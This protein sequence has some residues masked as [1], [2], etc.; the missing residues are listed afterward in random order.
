MLTRDE[1]KNYALQ[2]CV[3]LMERT[4]R[5]DERGDWC[6]KAD[7]VGFIPSVLENFCRPFWG[8]APILAVGENVELQIGDRTISVAEYV[9][10]MLKKGLFGGER[11]SWDKYRKYFEQYA[12]ENQ[13]ITELAG[14]AISLFFAREAL[15]D[16]MDKADKERIAKAIYEMAEVAYEHSWPNN[17]YWFPLFAIT[18]LK[19]LGYHYDRTDEMLR[20]GLA[21][22]DT[23]YLGDGWYKD[24]EFGRFDYYEAWS[25]H[26]YPL[27]WTLIADDTFEGYKEYRQSF[28]RRTNLFLP[29]FTHWFGEDGA[30]VPFGRS[31]SYRFAAC[32]L[33]PVAV[34]A[35][36]DIKPAMAGRITA[37]NIGFFKEQCRFEETDIIPEG[38]LYHTSNV[39]ES[40]TSDGGAYWCCKAFLALLM[41]ENHPFWHYEDAELPAEKGNY[42]VVPTYKDIHILFEGHRGMVT[43]YNNT[44]QYYQ[45]GQHTHKFGDMR[46][47]YG[48]FVYS[49]AVGFGCSSCDKVSIDN[50]VSLMTTDKSMVSHRLG[51]RDL[52]YENGALHSIH[53]PFFNDSKS[54]IESWII[55]LGG[56]HV[57]IHKVILSQPYYVMEGGFAVGRWDDYCLKEREDGFAKVSGREYVSALKVVC[58]QGVMCETDIGRT[59]A[60]Y[61]L[62]A[63]LAE[64]PMYTTNKPL[65]AGEYLFASAFSLSRKDEDQPFLPD[66]RFVGELVE[67]M[68]P[69]QKKL[70]VN[71]DQV[72]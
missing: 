7:Q 38:Y 48:K 13:N 58:R 56:A 50:M 6:Y 1:I 30:N 39:V 15:W 54:T 44:A 51:Y 47:W 8:I 60:G 28:I 40:Y 37:K 25:L 41:E 64:Y 63:P 22:L 45:N 19:R 69:G 67:I 5:R 32:A 24:G 20:T 33:F 34:L 26:L 29:F 3:P 53:T 9:K 23:L 16:P 14:L 61:H 65:E 62:Y 2:I 52:G 59:Q 57:R 70:I 27:L 10:S 55:P 18:V 68:Q 71:T 17:H 43:M 49:S 4:L 66:F 12:Y 21:F 36:C 35:G 72:S 46:G 31:L 11:T 42:L